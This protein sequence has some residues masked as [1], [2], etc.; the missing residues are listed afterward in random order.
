MNKYFFLIVVLF[1]SC[2]GRLPFDLG[3]GYCLD[4]DRNSYHAVYNKNHDAITG[5]ILKIDFDSTFIIALVKPID[6]IQR[7]IR[8]NDSNLNFEEQEELIKSNTIQEYW[9]LNKKM[10]P[11]L[12]SSKSGYS[13]SNT[14]GPYNK[15]QYN[16]KRKELSVSE[17][18][19]LGTV[20][21]LLNNND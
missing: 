8:S 16:L 3:N 4:Y 2:E 11:E 1:V 19:K 13:I 15:Q 9:I 21:E 7:I 20:Q 17:N 10:K 18:L 12:I 14:F 5:H 6:K